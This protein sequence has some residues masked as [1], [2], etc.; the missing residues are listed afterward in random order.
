VD[1]GESVDTVQQLPIKRW[2]LL[3]FISRP[4][5]IYVHDKN[6]LARKSPILIL[7]CPK[8]P[9]EEARADQEK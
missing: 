6:L 3:G 8:R 1:T 7:E 5:G 4:L 2:E 9:H